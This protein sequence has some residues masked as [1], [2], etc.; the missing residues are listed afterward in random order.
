MS[1]TL[2]EVELCDLEMLLIGAFDPLKGFLNQ[3]D[4]ISV[5]NNCHLENGSLWP[6]PIILCITDEDQEKIN[7]GDNIQLRNNDGTILASLKVES[8]YKIDPMEECLK[9]AGTTDKNHP[10]VEYINRRRGNNVIGGIITKIASISH[11]NY[12]DL[13]VTPTECKERIKKYNNVIGFQTRNPLHRSHIE[14]MIRAT[15]DHNAHILLSPVVG[16]TQIGDIDADTRVRCYRHVVKEFPD[17]TCTLI[18][19]PL[20]MRMLGPREAL[21]HALI[22]QNYGC[23]HF[24]IG[25]DHAG[26]SKC[27]SV[28]GNK[29]YEPFAAHEFVNKFKYELDIKIIMSPEIVYVANKNKYLLTTELEPDDQIKTI[30]G[31]QFRQLLV[32]NQEIPEWFSY[33]CVIKE[34]KKSVKSKS[35]ICI[36]IVGLSGSGKST[37]AKAI[38][39]KLNE[40][41]SINITLLDGDIIRQ[42]LS[43]ELGFTPKDRSINVRRIGFIASEI[44]KHGG[45]CICANI[46]PYQIDR[47]HNRKLIEKV[48]TYLEVFVD[49]PIDIC[50]QRD[51]KG[52]YKLA[53]QGKIPHFTGISDPFERP[54]DPEIIINHGSTINDSTNIIIERLKE[55]KKF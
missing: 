21:W 22:R 6:V 35:G 31:T 27:H 5:I 39:E 15:K 19:I 28:S 51:V 11:Y 13:R 55:I 41:Y 17:D 49:T 44:V 30:S 29:F 36:Y 53:R 42:Y 25:R 8:K 7:V 1:I 12:V 3:K 33:P 40:L 10:Y 18:V 4:Y 48:G 9:V 32:K 38:N 20:A 50:E 26:P 23:S 45:I 34:L 52:L 16:L 24:I 14:L 2:N 37:I 54:I 47:Q 43:N 46:A